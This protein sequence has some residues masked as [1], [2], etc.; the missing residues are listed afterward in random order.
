M[1][2]SLGFLAPW[3][4]VALVALPLI[5]LILRLTPPRPRQVTFPPTRLLMELQDRERTP[6]RTP[7]W[8]TLLRL[9]LVALVVLALAE[10]ILRPDLKL[11]TGADPLL[12][13]LDNGWDTAPDFAARIEAAETAIAE[14]ARDGRPVALVATAEPRAESLSPGSAD[15][16]RQ[17]LGAIA[18]R[19]YIADHA[20]LA[21]RLDEE[22]EPASAEIVWIAGK[23]DGGA[24]AAL[25]VALDRIASAGTMLQSSRQLTM[26]RPPENR[27]E[28]IRV[29]VARL[30]GAGDVAVAGYDQEGRRIVESSTTLGADGEGVV[31]IALPAEIRNSLSRFA[32]T[33]EESAGAVQLLDGRWQRKAVGLIEGEGA[34]ASQPLLEPLT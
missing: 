18:P 4:L 14:A 13:V 24:A 22:F 31:E 3:L 23:L 30:G 34:G 15:S 20:A 29:P 7:W 6:A 11:T 5:W 26:L 8:L 12:L 32:V 25:A 28:G 33:G 10:P 27:A 2:G 17:R 1:I 9:L 16:A 19:P 21:G